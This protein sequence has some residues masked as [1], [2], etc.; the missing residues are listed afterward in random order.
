MST[1]IRNPF[2]RALGGVLSPTIVI[3]LALFTAA[4]TSAQQAGSL[5]ASVRVTASAGEPEPARG[6]T[7]YLLRKSFDGICKEA[8]AAEPA[9]DMNLFIDKLEVS[10]ELKS[11][12]KTHHMVEL[13]G[14][15]FPKALVADDVFNIKEIG[16]AF[17]A[18]TSGDVS[19]KLPTAKYLKVNREKQPE[20]YQQL[21]DEYH[22]QM[23]AVIALHPEVFES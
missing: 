13:S 22:T 20:K 7:L 9:L 2:R 1:R 10:P 19:I 4:P 8:E 6:L 23:R 18:R 5:S 3:A 15:A 17:S 11:W 12:M 21:F 16:D 14:P